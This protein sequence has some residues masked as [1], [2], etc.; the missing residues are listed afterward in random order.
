MYSALK[1][2]FQIST[3]QPYTKRGNKKQRR[4]SK[5]EKEKAAGDDDASERSSRVRVVRGGAQ[6]LHAAFAFL[7]ARATYLRDF[8]ARVGSSIRGMWSRRR[9]G[10]MQ[11]R[12]QAQP[13]LESAWFQM[14]TINLI[15]E[16]CSF[17][18]N[19]VFLLACTHTRRRLR[20]A[21]IA[22]LLSKVVWAVAVSSGV[23]T[24]SDEGASAVVTFAATAGR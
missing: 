19:L 15:K 16:T 21:L 7:K 22:I 6:R 24:T 11:A 14:F 12:V 4:G 9:G 2:W 8:R 17:N 13:R 3:L 18:L 1:P 5:G 10:A 20:V 23:S